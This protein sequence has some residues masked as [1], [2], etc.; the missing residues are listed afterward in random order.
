[1]ILFF[2]TQKKYVA[3][4]VFT[5]VPVAYFIFEPRKTNAEPARYRGGGAGGADKGLPRSEIHKRKLGLL[6]ND[7]RERVHEPRKKKTNHRIIRI[8][9][10]GE[11]TGPGA[12]GPRSKDLRRAPSS[13][14]LKA[15]PMFKLEHE[16]APDTADAVFSY[17]YSI[18]HETAAPFCLRMM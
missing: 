2:L 10:F 12:G 17:N 9:F 7:E 11:G 3:A 8:I 18:T 4:S 5:A 14:A 16:S 1:M 13:H 6:R 15:H